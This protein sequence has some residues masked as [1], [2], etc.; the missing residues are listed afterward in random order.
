MKF[1]LQWWYQQ[2]LPS[3]AEMRRQRKNSIIAQRTEQKRLMHRQHWAKMKR[4][5][6]SSCWKMRRL[7]ERC[8]IKRK[9]RGWHFFWRKRINEMWEF[10]SWVPLPSVIS[11]LAWEEEA[12]ELLRC[13]DSFP[14]IRS[15]WGCDW[16]SRVQ[17][18]SALS[19][20]VFRAD[21]EHNISGCGWIIFRGSCQLYSLW[22]T[23]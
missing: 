5:R 8:G 7:C 18:E 13:R 17:G 12:P 16:K 14:P 4:E 11:R 3:A 23:R 21:I 15:L 19:K 9:G 10:T 6:R 1:T 22:R 20:W 2:C